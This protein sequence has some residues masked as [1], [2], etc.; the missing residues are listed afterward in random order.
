MYI[1]TKYSK[2]SVVY[3]KIVDSY[4]KDNKIIK[5]EYTKRCHYLFRTETAIL[6]H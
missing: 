2:I 4:E 6:R 3:S 5:N 1:V